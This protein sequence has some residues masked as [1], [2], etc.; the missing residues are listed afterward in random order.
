MTRQDMERRRTARTA[1]RNSST[2]MQGQTRIQPDWQPSVTRM[3]NRNR[4]YTISTRVRDIN[5][6]GDAY[7]EV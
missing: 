6:L 3:Q 1:G 5:S 2:L 7:D 4:T